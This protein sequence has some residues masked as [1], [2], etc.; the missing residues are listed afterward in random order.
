MGIQQEIEGKVFS[1][2]EQHHMIDPHDH[3]VMGVSGGAD[4]VCLFF[5]LME[6][7]KHIPLRLSVVHVNHNLRPDAGEDAKYVEEL[8]REYDIPFYLTEA[9]VKG[10]ASEE[11]C[12]EEDAG[13]RIRYEAFRRTAEKSGANKIAVAHNCNDRAETM[14]FHLFRGSGLKGLCGILPVRQ[15]IIRPLLC[16][17]R[18]EI[19]NYLTE[20]QIVW[21]TD[22]TNGSDEYARNRIRRNVLPYVEQELVRGCVGHMAQTADIL[23]ET[24]RYMQRQT[25]AAYAECVKVKGQGFEISIKHFKDHH[26]AIQKRLLQQL[27]EELSP[28]GKD[29]F[30][31]H[32]RELISLFEKV[33]NRSVDLPMGI[34][35]VRCYEN[36]RL[37]KRQDRERENFHYIITKEDLTEKKNVSL[38]LGKHGT[39]QLSVLLRLQCEEVP[40]NQCTKWFNYDKIEESLSIRNRESGD[41]LSIADGKGGIVHKSVKDHMIAQKI[42]RETRNNIPLLAE[43]R[44]VLWVIGGRSSE[45]YKVDENTEH[46]LQVQLMGNCDGSKMEDKNG[47]AY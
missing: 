23:M 27:S 24:E 2:L 46:I 47:R 14:L 39:L 29:I 5:V 11:K 38:E 31:V 33:G 22:S 28:T 15:G 6:Y 36:V 17:E 41:F 25:Q 4:S 34:R 35:G 10:Y 40:Q 43:G 32:I 12:S 19:E 3:I 20:R 30:A 18:D 45:Y 16:L 42:P 8:C 1:F 9:D 7:A 26:P 13:R 44:H 21:R 37:E